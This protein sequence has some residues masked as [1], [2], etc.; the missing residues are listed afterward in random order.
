MGTFAEIAIIDY[1]L[2]FADQGKHTPVFCFCL[3][4]TNGNLPI[5][6]SICSKHMEVAVFH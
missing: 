6:F 4:Q 3:L 1:H 5:S 2:S